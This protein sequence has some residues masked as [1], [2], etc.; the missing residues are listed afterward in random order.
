M[1]YERFFYKK[2]YYIRQ[3]IVTLRSRVKRLF[4]R[5]TQHG[6][7]NSQRNMKKVKFKAPSPVSYEEYAVNI[8]RIMTHALKYLL[9]R[10]ECAWMV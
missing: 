6:N 1:Y 3:H 9:V 2:D 8:S 4:L 7:R 5:S 10:V